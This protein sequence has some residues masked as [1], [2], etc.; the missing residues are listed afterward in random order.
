[1]ERSLDEPETKPGLRRTTTAWW[2]G[3]QV[4]S[5]GNGSKNEIFYLGWR[6]RK[7]EEIAL[8]VWR[9]RHAGGN[10]PIESLDSD[11]GARLLAGLIGMAFAD[12]ASG[13]AAN[14]SRL[15]YPGSA[16]RLRI[17]YPHRQRSHQDL[18]ESLKVHSHVEAITVPSINIKLRNG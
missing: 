15:R 13:A 8:R 18:D 7:K 4:P 17:A 3:I 14:L 2:R 9:D 12:R 16:G 5:M 10:L 11:E 1:M 6:N